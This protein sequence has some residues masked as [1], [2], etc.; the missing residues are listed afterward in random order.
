VLSEAR[1]SADLHTEAV[2]PENH[3]FDSLRLDSTAMTVYRAMLTRSCDGLAELSATLG[4]SERELRQALD[5]LSELALVRA[6][7]EDPKR[8]HAV[9]P[10]LG[11][12]MLRARQKA[13]LAAEQQRLAANRVAAARLIAEIADHRVDSQVIGRHLED[14]ES[15]RD[16]LATLNNRVE[17]EFLT[18]A[19]GGPQTMANMRE[20]RPLNERMLERGVQMRTIY[21]DS[22]RRDPAT[23]AYAEWLSEHG[24]Q[25]RTVPVLPNRMIICDRRVAIMAA[26]AADTSAGAVV[27]HTPGVITTFCALFEGTWQSAEPIDAPVTEEPGSLTRQQA[28]VMQL[29][30]EGHTDETVGR[31]LGM[32]TRTA[33]RIANGLMVH[34]DARSR[35]Q[36]GTRAVQHGYLPSE[37]G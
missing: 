21:L 9:D 2:Q 20:S 14:L 7:T 8:M 26:D 25:I 23:L 36:A 4:L 32:S 24:A 11:L 15:I 35:F 33:R 12:E 34:L 37:S 29:L 1:G 30:A 27:L 5:R 22:I 18:F 13:Q 19:P 10:H 3:M 16:F 28:E 31:K 17:K 6:S